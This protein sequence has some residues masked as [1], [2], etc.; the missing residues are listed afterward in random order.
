MYVTQCEH[1]F[2]IRRRP[3]PTGGEG[4]LL[5]H[6]GKKTDMG[7][8]EPIFRCEPQ[9]DNKWHTVIY[10]NVTCSGLTYKFLRA[11]IPLR[12]F[13]P[14]ISS[15]LWLMSLQQRKITFRLQEAQQCWCRSFVTFRPVMKP[16]ELADGSTVYVTWQGEGVLVLLRPPI[17]CRYPCTRDSLP[18]F[19]TKIP[20]AK[21]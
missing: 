16:L 6:G 8:R 19:R 1:E 3:W 21:N 18:A 20:L 5:R 17:S 12:V 10:G 15:W 2:S 13:R 14:I 11:E 7:V 9:V 4:G